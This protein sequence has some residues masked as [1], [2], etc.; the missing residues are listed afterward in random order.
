MEKAWKFEGWFY[1]RTDEVLGP[2][3][4]NELRLLIASGHLRAG[5]T[6]WKGWRRG[7]DSLL[8]PARVTGALSK[9]PRKRAA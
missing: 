9:A 3:S 6:V 7:R 1:H 2:L 4:P 8:L 5:E